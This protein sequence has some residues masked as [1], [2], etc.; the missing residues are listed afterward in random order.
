MKAYKLVRK[1][2]DNTYGPLF[3][4]R[5]LRIH[6]GDTLPAE[7]HPTTGFTFRPYWHCTANPIAPHLSTEGRVWLE[8]DIPHDSQV[9]QRPEHQGGVWYLANIVTF[10]R[11]VKP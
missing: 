8:V 11:E 4:N 5:K 7:E 3:I 6:I 9:F 1:R 2:K 10:I